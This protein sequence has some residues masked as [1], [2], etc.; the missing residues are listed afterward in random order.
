MDEHLRRR[1]ICCRQSGSKKDLLRFVW[2]GKLVFD[3][4]QRLPGRGAYVHPS[5]QCW[6]KIGDARKWERAFVS[7]RAALSKKAAS[8]VKVERPRIEKANLMEV[9]GEVRKFIPAF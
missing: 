7:S 9:M 4:H 3:Q 6:A 2:S 5:H 8:G 1:C